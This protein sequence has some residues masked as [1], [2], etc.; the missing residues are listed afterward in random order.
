MKGSK[1]KLTL[2]LIISSISLLLMLQVFWLTNSYEKAFVDLRKETNSLFRNTV[3]ALRDSLFARSLER[4]PAEGNSSRQVFL[5]ADTLQ[6]R[7]EGSRK[8]SKIQI[9]IS[10][11]SDKKVDSLQSIIKPLASRFREKH[12][13]G[14]DN[15]FVFRLTSDSLSQDSI[16]LAFAKTLTKAGVDVSFELKRSSFLPPPVQ[17]GHGKNIFKRMESESNIANE[18]GMFSNLL[19][20]DW[21]Q[22]DP[23]NRYSVILHDFRPILLKEITPQI[24]FSTF[25][26]LVTIAAFVMLYRNIRSQQKLMELKND[27]ISNMTHELKTPI[28]TVSVAL[29]ALKNFNGIDNPKLTNEYLDIA[30]HE[31]NRLTMLTDKVLK[32]SL[33]EDKG[34]DFISEPVDLEKIIKQVIASLQ[35]V[36]E[37]QKG[38]IRFEKE[39]ENFVVQG[40]AVHLTSVIYNLLDNALKYSPVTP[41]ILVKLKDKEDQILISVQDQGLGIANEFQKKIFEKFFRVP[42]GDVHNIKGYGLGLSYV[43]SVIKSHK[44]KIDVESEQGKGSIFTITLPQGN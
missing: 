9:Y 3:S 18:E 15:T 33:F 10:S 37:K 31:L 11:N 17:I 5:E 28:A 12:F 22:F 4:I 23:V 20:S 8:E 41:S 36:S 16:R 19:F 2:A 35:L 7:K 24:L 42:S 30:Q 38:S 21:V 32:T 40:G 26:T 43:D 1:N 14:G 29:E 27:F 39:G 34:V 6:I 13:K 44:G 25:L